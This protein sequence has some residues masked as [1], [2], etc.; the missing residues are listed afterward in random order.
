MLE[1]A[2]DWALARP[3]V[4]SGRLSRPSTLWNSPLNGPDERPDTLPVGAPA[5]DAP[6]LRDGR[7]DWL[8]R[9]LGGDWALVARE[10]HPV[11]MPGIRPLLLAD[12]PRAGAWHDHSG[13]AARRLGL[14]PG[15]CALIRPDQH[16]AARF[17]TCAPGPVLRAH[18]KGM[19]R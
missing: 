10:A 1:L 7:A 18:A 2:E 15:E 4:N 19:G 8:L 13:L 11:P 3:L 16:V 17:S 12:T 14:L 6:L 5:P 9:Q